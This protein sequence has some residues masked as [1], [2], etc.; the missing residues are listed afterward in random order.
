[1]RASLGAVAMAGA[2][3]AGYVLVTAAGQTTGP[4]LP[5]LSDQSTYGPDVY[6]HYCA[7]CHGTDGKGR[8][9]LA[10]HLKTAPTDLTTLAISNHGVFPRDRVAAAISSGIETPT[11][12]PPEMPVWGPIFHALDS[13]D[14]R[15]RSRIANLVSYVSS[16]QQ[17]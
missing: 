13:S 1:M 10:R 9:P 11:H 6:K 7:S 2:V 8:G 17:K 15:V 12:G 3:C 5:P 4:R 14:A 16:L